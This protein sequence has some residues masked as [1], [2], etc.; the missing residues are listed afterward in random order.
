MKFAFSTVACPQWDFD[1]I[2]SKAKE[3]GYDGVEIRAF[4][5]E[6][7]L[8]ASNLFLTDPA[9]LKSLFNYYQVEIACLASSVMF[10]QNKKLDA[11]SVDECRKFIDIAGLLN[12]PLVKIFDA[13]VRPG[14]SR[15]GAGVL[16]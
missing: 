2:A 5:D 9:K 10:H 3:Y 4:L 16:F 7:I 12:C 8:T 14:Q 15:Q 13:Q 11:R 1:T 6:S